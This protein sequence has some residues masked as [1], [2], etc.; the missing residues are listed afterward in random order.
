MLRS[1]R[2]AAR[3]SA[4]WMICVGVVALVA[5]AFGFISQSDK[6]QVEN[7]AAADKIAKAAAEDRAT[8]AAEKKR[9]VSVLLGWIDEKSADPESDLDAARARLAD[10]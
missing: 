2:G 8:E 1:N 10:E 7:T 4:V 3:V 6:K 5:L 9:D